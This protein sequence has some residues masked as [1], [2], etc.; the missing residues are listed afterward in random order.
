LPELPK[1]VTSKLAEANLRVDAAS[2]PDAD[3]L[4][5]FV[6][7]ALPDRERATVLGHLA[8]CA[9]CREVVVFAQPQ[10]AARDAV[11]IRSRHWISGGLFLRWGALAACAALAVSLVLFHRQQPREEMIAKKQVSEPMA[12][13]TLAPPAPSEKA[14]ED[15]SQPAP[16][17]PAEPRREDKSDSQ[18][19]IGQAIRQ[20]NDANN[21]SF[22]YLKPK[23]GVAPLV[24]GPSPMSNNA[25]LVANNSVSDSSTT[26]TVANE[27]NLPLSGRNMTQMV[28]IAPG[29]SAGAN[30]DSK[31]A[32]ASPADAVAQDQ[33]KVA[34]KDE[35]TRAK[36]KNLIV[37]GF[38]ESVAA[39]APAPII[40]TGA[41]AYASKAGEIRGVVVD[42]S[43]AVIPDAKVTITNTAT[44]VS[45]VSATN[46]AGLYDVSSV[47][48]GPYTI[49][50]SKSGFKEFVRQGVNLEPQ[51]VAV[52]AMLQLG[53]VS[54]TVEVETS[55][56]SVQTETSNQNMVFDKT[57][58]HASSARRAS[59]NL[60]PARQ[61]ATWQVT[62]AGDLQRSLDGGK[63]WESVSVGQPVKLRA[64]VTTGFQVWA[65]GH[66]GA[67]FHSL[68]GGEHFTQV[69]VHN[70]HASLTGD[71]VTLN[72]QDPRH[73]RIETVGHEVWT[74]SD[75]GKTWRLP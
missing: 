6:E 27:R 12:A 29:A 21:T 14:S 20:R 41:A 66:A 33:D 56:V 39:S 42:P 34:K 59:A 32:K 19:A 2:H 62:D 5:A 8:T 1:I 74:T 63:D 45:I 9:A 51:T 65:G 69:K 10:E 13:P 46:T 57:D 49:T 15:A 31:L 60:S 72:F 64:V 55:S 61:A 22:G 23:R 18:P 71:I 58:L 28:Q 24:R 35:E 16:A 73:G 67:L 40:E 37:G 30:V 54:E 50:V 25:G 52:N 47:P 26:N 75:G 44:R 70:R 11:L 7:R 17:T 38:S 53:A 36:E 3:L 43:G 4:T 48:I 68:D